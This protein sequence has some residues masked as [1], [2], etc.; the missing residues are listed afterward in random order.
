[1]GGNINCRRLDHETVRP[2]WNQTLRKISSVNFCR[3]ESWRKSVQ[4][5]SRNG[6]NKKQTKKKKKQINEQ[7]E[8]NKMATPLLKMWFSH[9][10]YNHIFQRSK[11]S[12][13]SGHR[14][15]VPFGKRLKAKAWFLYFSDRSDKETTF[16][17]I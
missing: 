3:L 12:I 2:A 16:Q 14:F 17:R 7:T 11:G 6:E 5:F 8:T 4:T 15:K 13:C 1:M 10:R 9:N